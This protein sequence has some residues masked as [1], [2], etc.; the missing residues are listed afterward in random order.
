MLDEIP[1][2]IG[3]T[4]SEIIDAIHAGADQADIARLEGAVFRLFDRVSGL[5]RMIKEAQRLR[6][7]LKA[8]VVMDNPLGHFPKEMA[9]IARA[10]LKEP[11]HD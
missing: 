6:E 4:K 8:I 11:S 10:A 5:E 9:D 2:G 1:E 3:A 7:A